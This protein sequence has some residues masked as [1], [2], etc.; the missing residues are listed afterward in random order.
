MDEYLVQ[1]GTGAGKAAKEGTVEVEAISADGKPWVAEGPADVATLFR[2]RIG[3]RERRIEARRFDERGAMVSWT[4]IDESGRQQVIDVDGYAPD[5]KISVGGSETM[6]V[7]VS[8]RRDVQAGG[9]AG[10]AGAAGG[11]LRAAMPG[12][13]VKVLCKVGDTVKAGQGLL[14]IEAMKMEN[15]VRAAVGGKV[16]AIAVREGQTVEGGA[17]LVTLS[18]E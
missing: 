17:P 10:G 7:K 6:T 16:T 4:L 8:D 2:V 15:E 18:G 5:L 1:I 12:K 11:D 3:D 9:R 14:I 13:V